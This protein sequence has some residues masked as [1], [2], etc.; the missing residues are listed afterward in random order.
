MDSSR[1][2]SQMTDFAKTV[3]LSKIPGTKTELTGHRVFTW[4]KGYLGVMEP[5]AFEQKTAL[6]YRLA[7]QSEW[8]LEIARYDSYGDPK[9][10]NVPVETNWGATLHNTYWDSVLTANSTLGIGEAAPWDPMLDTFFPSPSSSGTVDMRG[11]EGLHPGV[12]EFLKNVEVVTKFLDSIKK[13][14]PH[15]RG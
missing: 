7:H 1:I 6:R 15:L 5:T 8:E 10:E 14:L 9:K 13:E 3:K 4:K 11:V 2:S 12:T